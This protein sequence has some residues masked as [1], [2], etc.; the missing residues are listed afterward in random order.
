MIFI[1]WVGNVRNNSYIEYESTCDKNENL[2]LKE[3]LD[4]IKSYL[5]DN[6]SSRKWYMENSV[7]NCN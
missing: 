3:Y 2:S 7:N 5:K 4:K 1:N 6:W